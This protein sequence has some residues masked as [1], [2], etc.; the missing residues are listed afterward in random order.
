MD[1]SLCSSCSRIPQYFTVVVLHLLLDPARKVLQ[2]LSIGLYN[3]NLELKNS[4]VEL[5]RENQD[6]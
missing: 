6:Q 2:G 1:L 5:I 4:S 3:N